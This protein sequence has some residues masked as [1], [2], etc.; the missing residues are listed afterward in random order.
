MTIAPRPLDGEILR[1]YDIRGR[2][3]TN[4]TP[5]DVYIIGRAFAAMLIERVGDKASC[6]VGYDGRLSSIELEVR[7]IEGLNDSGVDAV[8]IGCG[9]TPMLSFAGATL[10]VDAALMITGSHNPPEYNGIKMT[11]RK[12]TR[13]NSSHSQ[14]SR[15]PSSA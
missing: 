7:L 14:Q 8:R 1:E 10:G 4:F 2:V 15:M 12:S 9:P 11:D 3:D 13:L 6:A 5:D